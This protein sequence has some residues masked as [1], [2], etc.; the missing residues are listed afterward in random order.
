MRILLVDDN[1]ADVELLK[2]LMRDKLPLE[3]IQVAIDGDEAIKFL[4]SEKHEGGPPVDLAIL[5]LNL[6]KKNGYEVLKEIKSD[7]RMKALPVVV[8]TGSS[9]EKDVKAAYELGANCYLLKPPTFESLQKMVD[10]LDEFWF[11][12]ALLPSGA[13]RI[14]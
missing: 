13:G 3:N 12:T 11:Q 4:R 9:S 2:E 5:D 8:L 7:P 14:G 10:M 6:P 1:D